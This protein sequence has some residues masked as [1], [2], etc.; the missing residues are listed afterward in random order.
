MGG[1]FSAQSADLHS[2]RV[3]YNGRQAFRSLGTLHVSQDGAVEDRP[4]SIRRQRFN[5]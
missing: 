5:G 3:S 2:I 4:V 1:S